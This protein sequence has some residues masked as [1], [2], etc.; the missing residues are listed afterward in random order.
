[1]SL[2]L[3][4]HIVLAEKRMSQKELSLKTG[5]RLPTI[6]AYCNDKAKHI[7][8]E[9]FNKFME[10]LGCDIT[11]LIEYIKDDNKEN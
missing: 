10:V 3:K 5:V 2:K 4:L 11:D 9:H 6:S 1:M 7:V 8:I